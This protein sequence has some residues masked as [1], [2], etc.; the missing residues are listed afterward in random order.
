M[1]KDVDSMELLFFDTFA[2]EGCDDYNLD[3]V[4]FPR[5]VFIN[6]LRVIP[7]GTKV[8]ADFPG[9]VRLGATNPSQ[10][11]VDFF[12]ND[13]SKT[14]AATFHQLG[15]LDYKHNVDIQLICPN[16]IPTDGLVLQGLYTTI[17]LAIYGTLAK[18]TKEKVPSPP[19]PSSSTKSKISSSGSEIEVKPEEPVSD[20]WPRD[21]SDRASAKAEIRSSSPEPSPQYPIPTVP[22]SHSQQ[23]YDQ[24]PEPELRNQEYTIISSVGESGHKRKD[25]RSNSKPREPSR[26]DRRDLTSGSYKD[27]DKSDRDREREK[28]TRDRER[29]IDDR[30][31]RDRIRERDRDRDR[32]V[33]SLKNSR[34]RQDGGSHSHREHRIIRSPPGTPIRR[35]PPSPKE[36][37]RPRT[38]LTPHPETFESATNKP[39]S[40][41]TQFVGIQNLDI[42]KDDIFEPLTPEVPLTDQIEMLSDG[43]VREP[44]CQDYYEEIVSDEEEMI[45]E[46][47]PLEFQSEM[48][49]DLDDA[50]ITAFNP[51]N[52]EI[53]P[54]MY[55]EDPSL[56]ECE[57]E[58]NKTAEPD[59]DH[60]E[61]LSQLIK[62][63]QEK[64]HT[65]KWVEILETLPRYITRI[66]TTQLKEYGDV[67]IDWVCDSLNFELVLHNTHIVYKLRHL[68]AGIKL[69][70]IM[71]DYP[72][73]FAIKLLDRDVQKK[74]LDLHSAPFMQFVVKRIVVRA[75]DASTRFK[76][77][78]N[79]LL[80]RNHIVERDS[81]NDTLDMTKPLKTGY[82]M[83]L[84]I[85]LTRQSSRAVVTVTSLLR[86][87]NFFETLEKLSDI[88]EGITNSFLKLSL[89]SKEDADGMSYENDVSENLIS[90]V[91]SW[92]E[93]NK[94]D[95]KSIISCLKEIYTIYRYAEYLIVQLII[96]PPI[97]MKFD[98]KR[99][100]HN[101]FY[102]IYTLF[103]ECDFLE[104]ILV[105]LSFPPTVTQP[106]V[107][108]VIK[109]ILNS[110]L[111]TQHGMLFLLSHH[112]TTNAIIRV[113][114][115][116]SDDGRE[117]IPFDAALQELGQ[118]M[119]H[120][121]H[122]LQC[123]DTLFAEIP[124]G[125]RY[126][127]IDDSEV[128]SNLHDLYTMTFTSQGQ[129]AVAYIL[130]MER[131]LEAIFPFI[132]FIG[133]EDHDLKL[134]KS[135]CMGYA[136]E[137]LLLT[138]RFSDNVEYLEK[139]SNHLLIIAGQESNPK[140]QELG[141]WLSPLR[142]LSTFCYQEI[143]Q[144][145][146]ILK[147]SMENVL[148]FPE[149]LITVLRILRHL[150]VPPYADKLNG[151][152]ADCMLEDFKYKY[153]VVLLHANDG[154][155]SL[156][157]ILEKICDTYNYPY[158]YSSTFVGQKGVLLVAVIKSAVAMIKYM[159]WYIVSCRS[160]E[161]QF[162]NMTSIV[163]LM[164]V[165]ALM[166][167]F[168][169]VSAQSAAIQNVQND[170]I[171]ILMT[172]TQPAV[173][174]GES[175]EAAVAESL[176]TKM[177]QEI[178]KFITKSPS[179]F[180]SSLTLLSELLPLPLPIQCH[181][182]LSPEEVIKAINYRKLW[183]LHL[184]CL[185]SEV[186]N[187]IA[188]V[189][190]SG[191]QTLHQIVKRVCVQLSDMSSSTSLVVIRGL[192]DAVLDILES[193]TIGNVA[194]LGHLSRLLNLLSFLVTQ[195]CIKIPLLHLIKGNT[196]V[197]KKYSEFIPKIID[198]LSN[199]STQ[200]SV[201]KPPASQQLQECIMSIFQS[202]C[203]TEISFAGSDLQ[204]LQPDQLAY[205]LPNKDHM[206]SV[207]SAVWDHVANYPSAGP[208]ILLALRT[209]IML[210]EHD[211]G[212]YYLKTTLDKVP[213]TLH[214][215]LTSLSQS[216]V[217]EIP[218]FLSILTAVLELI[219]LMVNADDDLKTRT[220]EISASELA[221]LLK[222]E[223]VN[224]IEEIDNTS[225][226][227]LES[228]ADPLK[229][230]KSH[231]EEH[232]HPILRLK[233]LL[234]DVNREEDSLE[235]QA[236]ESIADLIHLLNLQQLKET[237]EIQEIILPNAD[238]LAQQFNQR[239]PYVVGDVDEEGLNTVFWLPQ[240]NSEDIDQENETVPVDLP[241]LAAQVCP[242]FDFNV[243]LEKLFLAKDDTPGA[244]KTRKINVDIGKRKY[245]PI[246][247]SG[248]KDPIRKKPFVAPM[249]GRGYARAGIHSSRANDP[250]RSRPPN[251][252]RPPSMHVDDFVAME[253]LQPSGASTGTSLKRDTS[254]TRGRGFEGNREF[255]T[256]RGRPFQTSSNS[257]TRNE[258]RGNN[259]RGNSR[260]GT[261]GWGGNI[262]GASSSKSIPKFSSIS[263]RSFVHSGVGDLR[264]DIRSGNRQS[265]SSGRLLDMSVNRLT[266]LNRAAASAAHG[267]IW[268]S[269][270][271][272]TRDSRFPSSGRSN[273]NRE[274]SRHPRSLTR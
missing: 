248:S 169:A 61:K 11:R 246:I 181:E 136:I 90:D 239:V 51:F 163:V 72:K 206:A 152:S 149:E 106:A 27:S 183:S 15:G 44:H 122:V 238:S 156:L 8:Q 58:I 158:I 107:V 92:I 247:N 148:S 258:D 164:K 21:F 260:P 108:S 256:P 6:E 224:E 175:E 219:H 162:K 236:L 235:S 141:L 263:A 89:Q 189:G 121:L 115:P 35:H 225:Q 192:L 273:R 244:E 231:A 55:F 262:S 66:S 32:E 70:T 229:A 68:K 62:E 240:I 24:W 232:V 228:D 179:V 174:I 26:D 36:R 226:P 198:I 193:E 171:D 266:R 159:L 211:Y 134:K 30:G 128:L 101:P 209:L 220:Y 59:N 167:Y 79:M 49:Y 82:Q 207:C 250:F 259:I 109:D 154:M 86:K 216:Y 100:S 230:E 168:P 182:P 151:N 60:Q 129:H 155:S 56:T 64:L 131:N 85:L 41:V 39:S 34:D 213:D 143:P 14:G 7:L 257:Y 139:L 28:S 18:V 75:L 123:V 12:V 113:L 22:S 261:P 172:F 245:Q 40:P 187:V 237:V 114:L 221:Q 37:H 200:Q 215:F 204:I 105:L 52:C 1:A 87:I 53:S 117:D 96:L 25:D 253:T 166:S 111:S 186:Q 194:H 146:T 160:L 83:L 91:K 188:T 74:L 127:E 20:S 243:E 110:M 48:E 208:S 218:E 184:H 80:N 120:Y 104:S 249:R 205:S 38:P 173:E 177:I 271:G 170:V 17:T 265:T 270:S 212:F 81:Q 69:A 227:S 153:A 126:R 94:T 269:A 16:V 217:R 73:E 178:L 43:D 201:D 132:L 4:Q 67:L 255:S 119:A 222:W 84:E 47:E 145:C 5:P 77:G 42:M 99:N 199:I 124:P 252:S 210:T 197:D 3:L 268:S 54:Q 147:S 274:H 150:V 196:K 118:Q 102:G 130:G 103:N 50:Y 63:G 140:I 98:V 76:Y 195:P 112:E 45:E 9:G 57:I 95:L 33:K 233:K 264:S 180:V 10:F 29:I 251:T 23:E 46:D 93:S 242:N 78:L 191:D 254:R 241:G 142:K 176:W 157:T 185:S 144:L 125:Q 214:V 234:K 19:P 13:L 165:F 135:S 31:E 267:D 202:L 2:H 133:E 71:L 272:K 97:K 223:K 161:F 203:D 116:S 137:L 65:D 190:G 138:I 88:A